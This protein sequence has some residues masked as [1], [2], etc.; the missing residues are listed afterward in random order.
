MER[1]RIWLQVKYFPF[2]LIFYGQFF[3][4]FRYLLQAY[5]ALMGRGAS[6]AFSQAHSRR[7]LV[8]ILFK[9][10]AS[11]LKGLPVVWKKRRIIRKRQTISTGEIRNL[12]RL[13]GITAR[14]I[15]LKR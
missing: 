6:G 8:V 13:Y 11:A 4:I 9:V 3:T 5:G 1:N 10:W 12:L 2:L 15:A 14:E 7:D